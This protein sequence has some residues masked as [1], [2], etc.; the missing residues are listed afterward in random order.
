MSPTG[1]FAY[2]VKQDSTVE[3]RKLVVAQVEANTALIDKGLAVGE[4]VVVTG[5]NALS[6]DVKVAVQQGKPG[7]MNAKEPEIGPEGVGSTGITTAAS[8]AGEINPR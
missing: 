2:V 4:Q 7:E 3:V 6:P 8:G 1:P 5:Q